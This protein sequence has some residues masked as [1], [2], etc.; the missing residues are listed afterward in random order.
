MSNFNDLT[1]HVYGRLTVI[2]PAYK[3]K[4]RHW[5]W[6]CKCE[7]GK[8]CIVAGC[9]LRR[10]R[11]PTRSCGCLHLDMITKHGC[12]GTDLSN[13]YYGIIHRC[14]NPKSKDYPRYGGRGIEVCDEWR[15][16][17]RSF[18]AWGKSS[19]YEKGLSI[20]RI[21]NDGSYSPENCHWIS[22]A[23]QNRNKSSNKLITYNGETRIL[24]EWGEH[25]EVDADMICHR[26]LH[27]WTVERALTESLCN[28]KM[29]TTEDGRAHTIPQW[30]S[31]T[32]IPAA[33]LRSRI[34]TRG[35]SLDRAVSEPIHNNGRKK[36]P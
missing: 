22:L 11:N 10:K 28:K 35:W 32:G 13:I 34:K 18:V 31:I 27:G 6:N 33:T 19:G 36:S 24:E 20:D 2:S 29:Y 21:D 3:D 25:L 23:A 26:L 9:H 14:H 4:H 16:D 30:E 17:I 5:K 7:C 12:A 8:E 1:G 15:A